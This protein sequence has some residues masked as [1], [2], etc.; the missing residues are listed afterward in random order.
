MTN[1]YAAQDHAYER[2][3]TA[4]EADNA[5]WETD[6]DMLRKRFIAAAQCCAFT[7]DGYSKIAETAAADIID[8]YR[9]EE[10]LKHE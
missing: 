4:F 10:K 8:L 6:W 3:L 1:P 2:D 7:P 5:T 9:K